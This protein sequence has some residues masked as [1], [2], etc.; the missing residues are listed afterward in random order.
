MLSHCRVDRLLETL[1]GAWRSS[2]LAWKRLAGAACLLIS[3]GCASTDCL[4]RAHEEDLKVAW[5]VAASISVG[6]TAGRVF[7]VV[8][9]AI[10]ELKPAG[11]AFSVTL[12]CGQ[13]A[14][15]VRHKGGRYWTIVSTKTPGEPVESDVDRAGA[16][17]TW[18]DFEGECDSA[19]VNTGGGWVF[20]VSFD[21]DMRVV[22]LGTPRRLAR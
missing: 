12:Y 8:D 9:E 16:R 3:S 17:R 6:D 11:P 19:L 20:D 15:S 5:A 13:L 21:Q 2:A 1:E 22:D 7:D 10:H 14:R 4:V 18:L